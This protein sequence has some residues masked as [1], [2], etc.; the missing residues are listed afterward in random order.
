M[1]IV[2]VYYHKNLDI[3]YFRVTC[4]VFLLSGQMERLY[5]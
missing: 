4:I 1:K 5:Q 3:Q 2:N